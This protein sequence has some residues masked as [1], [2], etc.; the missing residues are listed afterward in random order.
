MTYQFSR[1]SQQFTITL[2]PSQIVVL[3]KNKEQETVRHFD[4]TAVKK[5]HLLA[6]GNNCKCIVFF[7]GKSNVLSISSIDIQ[8]KAVRVK[9]EQLVAY[10]R[11]IETLHQKLSEDKVSKQSVAFV[12]GNSV[13]MWLLIALIAVFL[14]AVVPMAIS[15]KRYELLLLPF[16]NL[17]VLFRFM[18]QTGFTRP[19]QPDDPYSV[20]PLLPK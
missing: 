9:N 6:N 17:I 19:Y 15:L 5:V 13:K 8:L 4:Y 11:F 14:L 20:S 7:Q 10:R 12:C 18:H 16:A 1:F 2:E 3:T